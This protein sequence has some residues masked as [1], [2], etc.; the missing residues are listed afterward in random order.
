MNECLPH[1]LAHFKHQVLPRRRNLSEHSKYVPCHHLL[2]PA[3]S[4][5]DPHQLAANVALP[6]SCS[7]RPQTDVFSHLFSH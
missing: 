3:Y 1:C 7:L 4:L 2:P 5:S 6:S